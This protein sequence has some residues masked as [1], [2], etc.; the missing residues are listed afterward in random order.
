MSILNLK[1]IASKYASA[2]A[3]ISL[4]E[5]VITELKLL[6]E[7]FNTE[8]CSLYLINPDISLDDKKKT[9]AD[10]VNNKLSKPV[11]N[12]LFLMLEKNRTNAIP[13]L[14]EAYKKLYYELK[15]IVIADVAAPTPLDSEE[16]AMIKSELERITDKK[17]QFGNITCDESLLAGL[18]VTIEDRRID[19]SIKSSLDLLRKQLLA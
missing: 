8:K 19:F 5:S 1:K 14:A 6:E 10:I 7:I 4:E 12:L 15:G 3:E 13:F 11:S 18:R 2:L 16:L 9:L 17:V